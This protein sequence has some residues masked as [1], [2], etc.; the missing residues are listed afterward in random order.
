MTN[1]LIKRKV[2]NTGALC[3]SYLKLIPDLFRLGKNS[4]VIDCGANVGHISKLLGSTGAKIISFEPDPLAF[5]YLTKRCGQK[6]NITLIQKGVWDKNAIIELYTHID[7]T[8]TDSSYTVGSSIKSDKINVNINKV[9]KA[10]VIDLILFM[11]EQKQRINLVKMDIEGAEIEI[12]YKILE[13]ESWH[14]FDRMYVETHETKIHSHVKELD[15]IKKLI[16]QKGIKN[17]KLNWI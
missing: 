10:E 11:Q 15:N 13:T 8:E 2:L 5:K 16:K 1:A 12:L 3:I 14:L 4:L 6:N 17:I 7:A 9:H